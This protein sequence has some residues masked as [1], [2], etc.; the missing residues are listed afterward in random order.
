LF[1][2][3]KHRALHP[4]SSRR[5]SVLNR[6]RSDIMDTP[7]AMMANFNGQ[8]ATPVGF[9]IAESADISVSAVPIT[10]RPAIISRST[11]PAEG[12]GGFSWRRSGRPA[13]E[14]ALHRRKA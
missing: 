2:R 6:L 3:G 8:R 11:A 7:L 9:L 10:V 14:L 13:S 1:Y 4:I 5:F 12:D